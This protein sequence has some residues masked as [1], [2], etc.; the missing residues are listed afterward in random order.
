[1]PLRIS[2]SLSL[3]L[4]PGGQ[5]LQLPASFGQT[6]SELSLSA[7]ASISF[8]YARNTFWSLPLKY[9]C[10]WPGSSAFSDM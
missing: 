2:S 9:V 3:T 6:Y 10:T 7:T 1:M 8:L 4:H 5:C